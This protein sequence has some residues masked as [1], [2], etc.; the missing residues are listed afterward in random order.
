MDP[1]TKILGVPVIAIV[2]ILVIATICV[3]EVVAV[4]CMLNS[5]TLP[6]IEEPFYGLVYIVATYF[7][8]GGE[9]DHTTNETT[10]R[11]NT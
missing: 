6:K 1:K 8:R 9:K 5:F 3:R 4:Y 2:A 11:S 7:F 10:G